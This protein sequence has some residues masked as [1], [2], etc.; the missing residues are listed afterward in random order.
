MRRSLALHMIPLIDTELDYTKAEELITQK[1]A[2]VSAMLASNVTGTINDVRRL[3]DM[4]YAH[5]TVTEVIK[6]AAADAAGAVAQPQ[7]GDR[8]IVRTRSP[9]QHGAAGSRTRRADARA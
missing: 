3:A 4:V 2:V 6:M 7:L 5:P 1:T 9:G 8:R